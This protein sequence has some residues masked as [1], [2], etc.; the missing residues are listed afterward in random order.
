[1][2]I[3]ML[4]VELIYMS[5]PDMKIIVLIKSEKASYTGDSQSEKE[6]RAKT[7]IHPEHIMC[8]IS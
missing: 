5:M 7:I 2:L 3:F 8:L 1:M 4:L 6:Q